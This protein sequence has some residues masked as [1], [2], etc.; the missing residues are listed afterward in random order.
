MSSDGSGPHTSQV[1]TILI[2]YLVPPST[3]VYLVS[4]PKPTFENRI[5]KIHRLGRISFR[6]VKSKRDYTNKN[7]S[8]QNFSWMY[9]SR[10]AAA[11]EYHFMRVLHKHSFPVPAPI[12]QSRH[13]VLMSL[14]D[15]YPLRQ[16]AELPRDQVPLLYSALMALIVRLAK[17]GLI[18]GDFNEFNLLIRKK[19]EDDQGAKEGLK[20]AHNWATNLASSEQEPEDGTLL[21][22]QPGER[23]ERGKCFERILVALADTEEVGKSDDDGDDGGDNDDE[24]EAQD[25]KAIRLADGSTVEPVLIDFPQMISVLHPNADFFFDRDVACVR[26]FF[27]KRFRFVSQEYPRFSELVESATTWETGRTMREKARESATGSSRPIRKADKFDDVVRDQAEWSDGFLDL[28]L[29]TR[30]S[31]YVKADKQR[32]QTE[33]LDQYLSRMRLQGGEEGDGQEPSSSFSDHDQSEEVDK[34][35][36]WREATPKAA[37]GEEKEGH[38]QTASTREEKG[39]RRLNASIKFHGS[40][41][42]GVSGDEDVAARVLMERRRAERADFKHHGRKSTAGKVG[43]SLYKTSSGSKKKN[44]KFFVKDASVF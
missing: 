38:A 29:L 21:T 42:V 14:I 33:E 19:H 5:L 16:I 32:G 20:Q 17:A 40:G 7:S 43:K 23:L 28:D 11:K 10:L 30:A 2:S 24:D 1:S 41:N 36:N 27:K 35:E 12:A 22:L 9:L 44:D 8:R 39:V 37:S 26:S 15:A 31:G 18:H 6:A 34:V 13:T 3:D 4:A 25:E